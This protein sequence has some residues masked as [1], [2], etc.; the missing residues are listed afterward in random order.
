MLVIIQKKRDKIAIDPARGQADF[1]GG[2]AIEEL[3]RIINQYRIGP[4]V[5]AKRKTWS[6]VYDRESIYASCGKYVRKTNAHVVSIL[7][8]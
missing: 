4:T 5:D 8:S 2:E 3:Y 7:A 6:E 1:R